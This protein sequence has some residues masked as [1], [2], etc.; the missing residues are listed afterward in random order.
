MAAVAAPG[1]GLGGRGS[2]QGLEGAARGEQAGSVSRKSSVCRSHT[3]CKCLAVSG[4]RKPSAASACPLTGAA[5]GWS[6]DDF[7]GVDRVFLSRHAVNPSR[8]CK[9]IKADGRV[10]T[11][12]FSPCLKLMHF[13]KNLCFLTRWCF[14][15]GCCV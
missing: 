1:R 13:Y 10:F 12:D 4:D 5:R 11:C 6:Q 8:E 2:P 7:Q 9:T 3:V 15:I 14:I